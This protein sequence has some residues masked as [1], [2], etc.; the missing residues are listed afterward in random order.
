[1]KPA[2]APARLIELVLPLAPPE[3]TK[4]NVAPTVRVASEEK[5]TVAL[6]PTNVDWTV[7]SP[8][9]TVSAPC[10]GAGGSFVEIDRAGAG[11]HQ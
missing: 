5:L 2:T 1:M 4:F 8:E 6:V 10:L 11:E 9:L 3:V 7:A